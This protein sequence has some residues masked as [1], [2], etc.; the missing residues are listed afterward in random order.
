MLATFAAELGQVDVLDAELAAARAE[1]E[2]SK[3][4]QAL[5]TLDSLEG[6]WLGMRGETDRFAALIAHLAK[7]DAQVSISG[8]DDA[9]AA[10]HVARLLWEGR[11]AEMVALAAQ[12]DEQSL[13][14]TGTFRAA[15]L[16][17]AGDLAAGREFVSGIPSGSHDRWPTTPGTARSGGPAVPRPQHTSATQLGATAYALLRPLAGRSVSAG[18]GMAVGPVDMFLA[19]A[20]VATGERDLAGGH[21]ERAAEQC[22]R[23]RVPL[24][25][26]W[27]RRER[28]RWGI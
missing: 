6:S 3:N 22:E 14:P 7:L 25:G 18:S 4:L 11:H 5:V 26:Q 2:A 8:I 17:R 1:A 28:E 24:A 15:M 13:L 23:W 12:V 27:V 10:L 16:C 19:L 20:A 21:A 9:V